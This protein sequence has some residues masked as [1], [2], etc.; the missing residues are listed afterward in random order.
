MSSQKWKLIVN[1]PKFINSIS[2]YHPTMATPSSPN[3][4]L[5]I[6]SLKMKLIFF[7]DIVK[8]GSHLKTFF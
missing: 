6:V 8:S 3:R 5:F 2:E 7:I 1:L 4:S